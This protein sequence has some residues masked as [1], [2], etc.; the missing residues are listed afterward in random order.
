MRLLALNQPN[1]SP[2]VSDGIWLGHSRKQAECLA[3]QAQGVRELLGLFLVTFRRGKF[4]K[5]R[6]Y[7]AHE[8]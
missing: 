6:M 1:G 3:C 2:F 4:R 8:E 5:I 7:L